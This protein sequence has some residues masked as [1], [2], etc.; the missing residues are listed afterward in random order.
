MK[1]IWKMKIKQSQIR[2]IVNIIDNLI[3]NYKCSCIGTDSCPCARCEVSIGE[4]KML[5][6]GLCSASVRHQ[7]KKENKKE[8]RK[9][10]EEIELGMRT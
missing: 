6:V 1:G 5:K 3:L 8:K 10:G 4:A 9:W 7:D 2:D